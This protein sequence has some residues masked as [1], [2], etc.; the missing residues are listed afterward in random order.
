MT[1]RTRSPR[2]GSTPQVRV[3]EQQSCFVPGRVQDATS[4]SS[5]SQAA[6]SLCAPNHGSSMALQEVLKHSIIAVCMDPKVICRLKCNA[7]EISSPLV[8]RL[9]LSGFV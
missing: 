6:A 8:E 2:T 4:N 1:P 5:G 9:M 3:C 7:C